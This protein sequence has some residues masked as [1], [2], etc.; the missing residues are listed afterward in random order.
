MQEKWNG[1]KINES[2]PLAYRLDPAEMGELDRDSFEGGPQ[3]SR[4]PEEEGGIRI[5]IG[6]TLRHIS[7]KQNHPLGRNKAF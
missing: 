1:Q 4:S 6:V 3:R 2:N 7:S 5:W